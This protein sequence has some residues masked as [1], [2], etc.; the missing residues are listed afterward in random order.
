MEGGSS[1]KTSASSCRRRRLELRRLKSSGDGGNGLGSGPA[2]RTRDSGSTNSGHES[3]NISS[4]PASCHEEKVQAKSCVP[5]L[6]HGAVSVIGRRREM[7]DAVAVVPGFSGEVSGGFGAYDFYGVY[8]GHGGARVANTCRDRM[9]L[10]LAE[11]VAKRKLGGCE[12]SSWES[13]M[14]ESFRRVD[15]EVATGSGAVPLAD[16]T[17]GSTAVVAVVEPSRIVVANCGDSRAVLSRGGK[18]VALSC[19]HKPDR[20]DELARVK[21][22]GGKVINWNGYRVLGVLATSRSIGDHYL[23][24]YVTPEPEVTVVDRSSRDEFL[25]LASDGLWD[26]ISNEIA[27]K[28]VRNCL[29]GRIPRQ[30]PC[31]VTG[32]SAADAA[33]ILAEVAVAQGSKDNISIVVVELKKLRCSPVQSTKAV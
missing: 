5:C 13:A 33:A 15:A 18:A 24:P 2:K 25:I 21:E 11:E 9:H 1:K 7:E 32:T 27:C 30:L 8:D 16:G 31:S 23:K 4:P 3:V 17:V 26:V 12:V 29:R 20:P 10:V 22:A 28:L 19:D 6:G 14:V